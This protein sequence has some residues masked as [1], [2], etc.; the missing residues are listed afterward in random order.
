MNFKKLIIPALVVITAVAFTVWKLTSNKKHME[1]NA[2]IASEKIVIFPVTVANPTLQTV[3]QNFEQ[4]GTFNPVHDLNVVSEVAG[5]ITALKVKNGDYVNKG[6]TLVQVDNEQTLIDLKVAQTAYEKSKSDLE[7]LE[8]MLEGNAATTQQVA[9]AK[10]GLRSNESKVLALQ[11]QLRLSSV[12]APISGYVNNFNLETGSFLSPGVPVA[13]I[14]DISKIKMVVKVLD[15]QIVAIKEGQSVAVTPDLYQGTKLEGKVIAVAS[16]AD[17]SRRF[18]VEIVFP[19]SK[20]NPLKAGMTGKALFELGGSKEAITIPVKSLIGGTQEPQVYVVKDS[21]AQLRNIV[22]GG[23]QGEVLEV[24]S[25]LE[26]SD[27]VVVTGQLNL[28]DQAKVQIIE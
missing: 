25:G 14:V 6:Q 24:V 20:Q 3:S 11:R 18:A 16:K 21:T 27:V 5:R 19:N 4:N 17:G 2:A 13:E 9:E 22:I 7:K 15:N 12:T 23:I 10:L 8:A 28:A 1:E 26:T